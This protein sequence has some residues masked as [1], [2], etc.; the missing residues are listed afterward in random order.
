MSSGPSGLELTELGNYVSQS[1][2]RVSS[3]TRVARVLGDVPPEGLNRATIIGAAQ[4]TDEMA[5]VWVP[6]N[7]R[8]W[9]QE[10]ATYFG[11]LQRHSIAVAVL[12][13]MHGPERKTGAE[14]AKRA[15]A[16]VRWMAGLPISQI[17][18]NLMRHMPNKDAAGAARA[19]ADR[20]QSIVATI[21]QIARCLHPDVQLDEL[22]RLLPVQLEFGVPAELVPLAQ[23]AGTS[24]GRADYLRL[25]DQ[26]LTDAAVIVDA[27]EDALLSC[28]NGDR[29]R[30]AA[31]LQAARTAHADG[32]RSDFADLL[33]SS[34]D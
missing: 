30:L 1:G 16:C 13:A 27:E 28:L 4:L 31:L 10:T 32:D 3:A 34:T 23:H 14:R 8:G 9:R 15:V 6:V 33:P 26:S 2:L 24:L 5:T 17:E 12:S 29:T 22:A 19:A 11:E 18:I 7:G 21:V 25:A 20:T